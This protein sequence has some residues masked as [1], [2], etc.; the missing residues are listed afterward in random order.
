M[1]KYR[2]RAETS[3]FAHP[4]YSCHEQI[5][6]KIWI[7]INF[8]LAPNDRISPDFQNP[9]RI[10]LDVIPYGMDENFDFLKFSKQTLDGLILVAPLI[11][12]VL[13]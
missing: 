12:L 8:F 4:V 5:F 2:Y 7:F 10:I 11:S 6:L 9:D 3:S 13:I 1:P